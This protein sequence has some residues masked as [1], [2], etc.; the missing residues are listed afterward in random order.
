MF[1]D[2]FFRRIVFNALLLF[3]ISLVYLSLFYNLYI[4]DN[5]I[6]SFVRHPFDI[7]KAYPKFWFHVKL[8]F[9][10]FS[11]L[12]SIICTN[13]LYSSFF[14]KKKSIS[15]ESSSEKNDLF[16]Q[17][18]N[19]TIENLIV[20][21][22]GLYQNFLITGT[23]GSG[24]TSSVMYPFT[25]Q[26]LNYSSSN[27]IKKLGMLILDVKGNFYSQVKKYALSCNRDDDLI[28]IE[29]RSG[30]LGIIL[31]INLILNLL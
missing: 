28:V 16:L 10:P 1:T 29:I 14:N 24:K 31:L 17:I 26:L 27:S 12:S 19:E 4:S 6:I 21:E 23:I 5:V 7:C 30:M 11:L 18:H 20:P 2:T 3:F 9:I 15:V 13:L 22:S 25:K 8:I